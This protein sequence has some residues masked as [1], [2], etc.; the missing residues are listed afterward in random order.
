MLWG[1][2]VVW[3]GQSPHAACRSRDVQESLLGHR[4]QCHPCLLT[5]LNV[6]A[7]D[8][9]FCDGFCPYR[10]GERGVVSSLGFPLRWLCQVSIC[11]S[12]PSGCHA[13]STQCPKASRR[14]PKHPTSE[15][16]GNSERHSSLMLENSATHLPSGL[17]SYPVCHETQSSASRWKMASDPN[18]GKSAVQSVQK[19]TTICDRK[20]IKNK[21]PE[22]LCRGEVLRGRHCHLVSAQQ[23]GISKALLLGT[24]WRLDTAMHGERTGLSVGRAARKPWPHGYRNPNTGK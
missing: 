22:L 23:R 16:W 14:V 19:K 24:T 3:D 15:G 13:R 6:Y 11:K 12:T 4:E 20:P 1:W 9:A 2:E 7:L 8:G 10:F 17:P 21:T 18:A 5:H